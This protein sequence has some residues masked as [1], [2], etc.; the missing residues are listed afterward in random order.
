[1]VNNVLD[2]AFALFDFSYGL[3][4]KTAV[5]SVVLLFFLAVNCLIVFFNR[6][7]SPHK[8]KGTILAALLGFAVLLLDGNVSL[9]PPNQGV[10]KTFSS[11][12]VMLCAANF[13]TYLVVDIVF[14]HRMDRNVPSYKRDLT[15][16]LVYL[17]FGMAALR[18]IFKFDIASIL[19]TTTVLTAAVAFAM[20]TTLSN[21]ISSFYVQNDFNLHRNTWISI[22]ENDI[23]G[24]IVNVG[25]RYTTI[26]TFDNQKVLVPNNHL[27][28]NIVRTLGAKGAN[29][30]KSA[31]HIKVG[32][33]YDMPPEKAVEM[34]RRILLQEEHV[35]KDPPP[36][37]N[38]T[39]FLDS[40][41]EYDMRYFL[42]DYS[43]RISTRGSILKKVLYAVAREGYSIPF[44]HREIISKEAAVPFSGEH[45]SVADA[46]VRAEILKSLNEEEIRK[47]SEAVHVVVF[48][49]GEDVVRQGE[50]GESLFIVRRGTLDVRID[51]A[52]VGTLR[53][54]N[55]F[56]EMSLLT[57]EKRAATV[58]AATEARLIRISKGDLEPVIRANP[59]LLE[60]LSAILAERQAA[61][62]E[63]MKSA[64]QQRTPTGKDA[65]LVKLKTFFG[66]SP[67]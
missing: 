46:L 13:L 3:A 41:V 44:P 11:L 32:L 40:S 63:Q 14:F 55:I 26:R 16:A 1:M 57:G 29:S 31:V 9:P 6:K 61:N 36:T 4:G 58:S 24:E 18:F 2:S 22:P 51:G 23:L 62:L 15:T 33:G 17:L 39:D 59:R 27:M 47:L 25:F 45:A 56:G 38:I 49:P 8:V 10:L 64:R 37:I 21:I 48:G 60:S 7:L 28:Q 67:G 20:Q 52:S 50:A 35:M 66:L 34:L 30:E 53:E 12:I 5:L 54:G 19:T 65:F 42:D 43:C